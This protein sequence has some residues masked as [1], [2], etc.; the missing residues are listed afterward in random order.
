MRPMKEMPY[1][2]G[3]K[4]RIYPTYEQKKYHCDQ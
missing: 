3:V 1:V 4:L 2:I